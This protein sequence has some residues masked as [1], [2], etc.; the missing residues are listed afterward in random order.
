[1]KTFDQLAL[2]I[3]EEQYRKDPTISYSRL[4]KFVTDGFRSV[5]HPEEKQT[6]SLNFG[7]IVDT[8]VTD[9]GDFYNKYYVVSNSCTGD[10]KKYTEIIYEHSNSKFTEFKNIP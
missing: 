4:S 6:K 3:S 1:M 5:W 9:P 2:P 10:V 7:S 8:L